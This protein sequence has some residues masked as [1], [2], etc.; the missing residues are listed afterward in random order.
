M[1]MIMTVNQSATD[2]RLHLQRLQQS[3][4]QHL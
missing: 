3:Q 4:Q 1:G 2:L